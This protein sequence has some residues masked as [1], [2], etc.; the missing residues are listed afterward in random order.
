LSKISC[1]GRKPVLDTSDTLD[2]EVLCCNRARLVETANIDASRKWDAEWLRTEYRYKEVERRMLTHAT[3]GASPNFD[4]ATRDAFTARD[5]SMGSS[6]GT[7]LVMMSTQSS[8]S[9]DFFRF[10]S[11]PGITLS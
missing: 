3:R 11:I 1:N 10:L 8:N 6:G 2:N 4:R 7:T 5:N 9:F